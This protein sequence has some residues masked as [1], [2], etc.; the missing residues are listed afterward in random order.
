[1]APVDFEIWTNHFEHH[2]RHPRDLQTAPASRLSP[3]DRRHTAGSIAT[4]QLG[5]RFRGRLL[6]P[7]A[8]RFARARGIGGL[9]RIVELLVREEQRHAALLLAYMTE[10]R[11][12]IAR[13]DWSDPL[14]RR[15]SRRA[16]LEASLHV[17]ISADLTAILCYRALEKATSCPRLRVLCRVLASDTLA[18]VGFESQLLLALRANRPSFDQARLRHAHRTVFIGT[19]GVAWLSHH[20]L[21]RRAG[22]GARSFLRACLSQYAFYLEPIDAGESPRFVNGHPAS[23]APTPTPAPRTVAA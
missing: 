6:P 13:A 11:I 5:E 16:G 7:V 10:Q 9:L 20:R 23:R 2:A 8:E 21:L 18:H 3:D 14:L 1:M 12:R 22:Y 15:L 17:L 19:V 4:F